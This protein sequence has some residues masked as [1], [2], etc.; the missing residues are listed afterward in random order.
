MVYPLVRRIR[1]RWVRSRGQLY[2]V[3]VKLDPVKIEWIVRKK[4]KGELTNRV[5]AE[6]MGVST[7]W[8]KKLWKRYRTDGKMPTIRKA[9]RRV[10]QTSPE[11]VALIVETHRE[12]EAGAVMLERV[13]DSLYRTHIPHN[14]VHRTLRSLG[15]AREEPRKQAKRKWVRYERR[16]SNSMW[17]TDWT[18]ID[19]KRGWLIAYLDD[20]SRFVVGYGL[21]PEAT[22]AHSVEVLK[23]AIREHGKPASILTDRGIQFYAVEADERLR[24][25]TV[26]ERYL[27][28][29][30]IRQVLSRVSHPQT[31]GKVERF[32]RTVKDKLPRF[33]TVDSLIQWYNVKRPH[34]SLNL[35]VMETPYQAYLRKMPETGVVIDEEAGEVYH[36]KKE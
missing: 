23:E 24:G 31:N 3:P 2:H 29:N 25:L 5:I 1:G 21:F 14:R 34:M 27:I 17:H 16:Y 18:L 28:E 36:A 30:E 19:G 15:L 33:G 26:F 10:V 4:E 11:D 22:S 7:I 20:A 6:S 12:Y 9:G 35:D 8:V 13:I 32:F